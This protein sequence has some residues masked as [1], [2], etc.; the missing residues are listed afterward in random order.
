MNEKRNR[1][2][3]RQKVK[4]ADRAGSAQPDGLVEIAGDAER[5]LGG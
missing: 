1:S 5:E 2:L 3:Q 4:W